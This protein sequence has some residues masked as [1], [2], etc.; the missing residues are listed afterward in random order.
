MVEIIAQIVEMARVMVMEMVMG[1]MEMVAMVVETVVVMA[2][3]ATEEVEN[4]NTSTVFR[5][6]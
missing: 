2:V 6:L 3:E 4:E 1:V 5:V